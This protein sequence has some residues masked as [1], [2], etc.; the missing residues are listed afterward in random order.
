LQFDAA[1]GEFAPAYADKAER[2]HAALK[3]AVRAG[4]IDAQLEH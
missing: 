3:A 4:I 1:I 2:D